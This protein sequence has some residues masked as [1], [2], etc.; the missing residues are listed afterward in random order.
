MPKPGAFD[1]A[2]EEYWRKTIAEWQDSNLSQAQFCRDHEIN[3]I[4]LRN[5]R[6]RLGERD[7][8]KN[9]NPSARSTRSKTGAKKGVVTRTVATSKSRVSNEPIEFVMVNVRNTEDI[10]GC[11]N[12]IPATIAIR[13]PNGVLISLPENLN[14]NKLLAILS[15]LA[16]GN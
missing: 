10:T 16:G 11:A 2:K 15:S 9:R 5:W 6:K 3:R 13:C 4:H 14:T 12:D 8:Q 7:G 1:N